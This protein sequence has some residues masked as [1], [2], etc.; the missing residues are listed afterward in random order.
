MRGSRVER[1]SIPPGRALV[2][3]PENPGEWLLILGALVVPV[4]LGWYVVEN[5]E[6]LHLD[7]TLS[8][9]IAVGAG[10]AAALCTTVLLRPTLALILLVGVVYLNLSDALIRAYDLPSILQLLGLPILISAWTHHGPG[11]SRRLRG[12]P[13]SWM[14]AAYTLVV[15]A[16]STW[17]D[18][19]GLSDDRFAEFFKALV[20]YSLVVLL[21]TSPWRAR[22]TAWTMVGAGALLGFLGILQ[23]TL[24]TREA[25]GGLARAERAQIYGDTFGLR[26]SGPLGDPNF[27]AQILLVLVPI[28]LFL[29]WEE[30]APRIKAVAVLCSGLIIS[31]CV[32]TYSR[33]GAIALLFVVMASLVAHGI[34]WRRIGLVALALFLGATLLIPRDFRERLTTVSHLLV[35]DTVLPEKD[36]SVKERLVLMGTAW[37][38][39]AANPFLGIGAGNYTARFGEYSDLFGSV[40]RDYQ[41]PDAVRYPHNLLLEVGAETGTV[42]LCLFLGALLI[43]FVGLERARTRFREAG[44]PK[45]GAL[46]RALQISLA[47]F[48]VSS[49]FLHG[50]FERYLWLL[51]GMAG[52]LHAVGRTGFAGGLG[53]G[54]SSRIKP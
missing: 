29:I 35:D 41:D 52:A 1:S 23:L 11:V 12:E 6:L 14:L 38:M 34:H 51:F 28:A 44:D 43:A 40:A 2:G 39:M 26:L 49:L 21:V 45:M 5:P 50:D 27:F 8:P 48:L 54:P 22:V 9:R 4:I 53:A 7:V 13:L 47:G 24:G 42:G 19:P 20:L 46:A 25:F 33:G 16:S 31:A 15:L 30:T 37:E 36:S 18:Q 3:L 17:A 32:L 10:M